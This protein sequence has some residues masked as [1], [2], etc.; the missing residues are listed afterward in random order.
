MSNFNFLYN[1]FPEI[2]KDAVEAEQFAF[3]A[4]RYCAV[5]CRSAME[6]TVHW[7]YNHDEDLE[8]PLDDRISALI[9]EPCFKEIIN[10]RMFNELNLIRKTGNNG[11]HGKN[12]KQYEAL[13]ALK[14]LFR[15]VSF[16]SKGYSETD[17]TIP[18]FDEKL[19][20]TGK[21]QD[22]SK[23]E[24][25][26]VAESLNATTAQLNEER[27]LREEKAKE[28]ELLRLQI[29]K[30]RQEITQRKQERAKAADLSAAVPELI[31]EETTRKIY[32]DLLLKE[33][34]WDKLREGR[35]I[36]FEVK[37]MPLSTNPT[38]IGYADYVLWGEDGKPLAVIEA[39]RTMADARKGKHQAELYADC[40]EKMTAQRPIIFYTNGFDSYIWD[41]TFYPEREVSGFYTKNELQLLI[42]RRQSRKD[43]RNFKVN[44][45]I[46]GRPYQLEGIQRVAETFVTG[47][48]QLKGL[49]RKALM[50]MATGSGKTRVSAAIVD[51]LTKC[52]WV[53]RVLFLADRNALVTQAKNAFNEHVPNLTAIDLTQEKEDSSTRLVFS[54]YPT[55]MNKIDAVKTDDNRFYGV[56]HF[57]LII[58]D[59]A[60]RSV[61]QKYKAIF[62]YFDSLLIGLTATPK[63]EV[64]K[65]TYSLFQI[66]DDNPT[67]A[68][69]LDQA[70]KDEYLVPPKAISVP[71]K[72]PRDGIK[73]KD[74]SPEEQAEYEEKFGDPTT[75]ETIDE[76]SS[77]AL[78]KW[79]FNTDTVDKVLAYVMDNGIKFEGG[80]KLGKTILFARN[81]KHAEFIEE[82]F[83]KN[84][85]EYS[86]KFLR[87]ID[88]Y[89]TKAQDLLEKFCNEE[90]DIDPQ[91]AVSVDMMDTGVDAPRVVNLVFFKLV[92]SASKFWQMIGRGTR[93]KPDLFGPGEDKKHF[94]IFDFC[95][96]FEFFDEFP[97]G[98]T[99]PSVKSISQQIFEAKLEV[100]QELR[101][102]GESNEEELALAEQYINYLHQLIANLDH[103]RFVVR[104]HLRLVNRYTERKR[105]ENLSKSDVAD[106][107]TNLTALPPYTDDTDEQA[108]RFDLLILNLQLALMFNSTAQTRLITKIN[109]IGR[110][111]LKKKN[112]PAV[113]EQLLTIKEVQQEEFWAEV[114]LNR[115]EQVRKNLRDLMKFLDKESQENVYTHFEDELFHD[116]ISARDVVPVYTNLQSYRDRVESYVR[117]NKNHLTIR[118]LSTNEPITPAE[119]KELERLLFNEETVGTREQFLL[120]YGEMPLGRF[121]RSIVGLEVSAANALFADFIQDTKLSADQIKFI[122]TII[123]Y[124]TTNGVIDKT[125]LFEPP[126]TDV[127][128]Q[129]ITGVFDDADVVKIVSLIDRVND[130]ASGLG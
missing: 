87:I 88:N 72:F 33:A 70:V 79:L 105:W 7:L 36:E 28:N 56:G 93:L 4:P 18:A 42:D 95:E 41:D 10:F 54:T 96:N 76:I 65:N 110:N 30:Q 103:K 57:D 89:E 31:S 122:D 47:T 127:N 58:I 116:R 128:D 38:G 32:I 120:E 61:Y 5:L 21:E 80:D 52:N 1:E 125:M 118:K 84:Y 129:G 107:I 22:K 108:K 15:F 14:A 68:Y 106:I 16:L 60:H 6:K 44:T 63:K 85:P 35:E 71:L 13:S 81:H 94:L 97:E 74:L 102:N 37:G 69:E 45:N 29:E 77:A 91:I 23:K 75:G 111:L 112:I 98:L 50:V 73:Y 39:K 40:L 53:K 124:L 17:P 104:K 27:K 78:N 2:W 66:E 46:A 114:T 26:E 3:I 51:M 55:I 101:A 8:M 90:Y 121:I 19:I 126:F 24:L 12:I 11:A 130:N 115:L 62:E 49:N 9:H 86:G 43:I 99:P 82:R 117:K 48:T 64:D 113:N 59:E 34:G 109:R 25:E 119:V 67:F 100:A 83:N 123:S 20:P 92:R